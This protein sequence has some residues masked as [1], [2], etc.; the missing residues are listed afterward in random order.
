MNPFKWYNFSNGNRIPNS[1]A[2]IEPTQY[3]FVKK[4]WR[5]TPLVGH[6]P[7]KSK[8]FS[9]TKH[10]TMRLH[11]ALLLSVVFGGTNC[12]FEL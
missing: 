5:D 10:T 3:G 6:S 2:T 9:A 12:Y 1:F 11:P 8:P 4:R 7:V